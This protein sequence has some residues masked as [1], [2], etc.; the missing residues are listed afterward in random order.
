M[1]RRTLRLLQESK[2]STTNQAAPIFD[3]HKKILDFYTPNDHLVHRVDRVPY[4]LRGEYL[5]HQ[6]QNPYKKKPMNV[7]YDIKDFTSYVLP[8]R[9]ENVF[10]GWGLEE[11]FGV[12][13][14]RNDSPFMREYIKVDNQ[15]FFIVCLSLILLYP[16]F[17]AR[18][19]KLEKGFE[20]YITSGLGKF[21]ADDLI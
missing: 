2:P 6:K 1:F 8:S 3:K 18:Q 5:P 19:R 9:R 20:D 15:I 4:E 17:W 16:V 13:R 7:I 11:L 14:W 10:A 12:K 21:T